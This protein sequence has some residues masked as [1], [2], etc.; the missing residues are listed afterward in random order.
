MKIETNISETE[1]THDLIKYPP[2]ELQVYN[3]FAGKFPNIKHENLGGRGITFD[4]D[5]TNCAVE[6]GSG[7]KSK[8]MTVTNAVRLSVVPEYGHDKIRFGDSGRPREDTYPS[9]RLPYNEDITDKVDRFCE[10]VRKLQD[11]EKR[12]AALNLYIDKDVIEKALNKQLATDKVEAH[13]WHENLFDGLEITFYL[14]PKREAP[15]DGISVC[16]EKDTHK[17]NPFWNGSTERRSHYGGGGELLEWVLGRPSSWHQPS[18]AEM[19]TRIADFEKL[20]AKVD[21]FD[22]T[23]SPELMQLLALKK[24]GDELLEEFRSLNK[25]KKKRGK[26]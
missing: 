13:Y 10:A 1:F 24:Q 17:I 11:L 6:I 18:L 14:H 3:I 7:K 26:K 21:A 22:V 20:K 4:L 25:T 8:K 23:K 16:I 19:K 5:G 9:V 15:G 12:A 2:I